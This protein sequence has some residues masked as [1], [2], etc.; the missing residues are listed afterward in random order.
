MEMLSREQKTSQISPS[1]PSDAF[2]SQPDSL[3]EPH[4]LK[5]DAN[6]P[7]AEISD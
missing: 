1:L 6:L 2:S 7:A 3:T 5:S 4:A